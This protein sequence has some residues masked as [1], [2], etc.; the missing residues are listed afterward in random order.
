M[1][2]FKTIFFAVLVTAFFATACTE[3]TT[4]TTAEKSAP[5]PEYSLD[6]LKTHNKFSS[7]IPPVLTVPDG[8]VVRFETKEASDEQFTKE[9]TVEAVSSLDFEPIH[10]LTGP[11]YV[12]SAEPGDVLAVTLHKID[13]GD[14][15]W[16]SIVP[17]FGFLAD[18]FTEPYL[19]IFDIPKGASTI[20]FNENIALP[21]EPFPGV[22]GVAPATDSL[23][24]TIP[25]RQN[26][27]NMDNPFLTEGVTVY[28]PVLVKG[29]LFSIGDPH[30]TQG[31]GEVC[32]TAIEG[33]LT[34]TCE[35]KVIKGGRKIEEAQ[36]E[37]DSY[38]ATTGYAPTIDEA[39]KK[40]TKY[41]IDYLVA[42][43]GLAREEAYVL[44]S[45]AGDLH[46]AE[47]VDVPN[48]LV[49]MHISKAVFGK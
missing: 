10:P 11:V 21:I 39:A 13:V 45:L 3:S 40:A 35:L 32:G 19:K 43:H 48:M 5:E 28:F 15:G 8:A 20:K 41:M 17:G 37:T 1:Q 23:L 9:S 49:A 18:E 29:A 25:P 14:W 22:I 4:T 36:Y 38:Y 30:V 26:G 16:A 47:T 44:C 31:L 2:F 24:N 27:G 33:P 42:E 46:I 6:Q 7:S 34:F 12:E